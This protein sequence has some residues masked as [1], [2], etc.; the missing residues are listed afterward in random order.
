MTSKKSWPSRSLHF[1]SGNEH[2][3][4][5]TWLALSWSPAENEGEKSSLTVSH[6]CH[7]PLLGFVGA[8]SDIWVQYPYSVSV[9]SIYICAVSVLGVCI[10]Y[11][12]PVL[13]VCVQHLYQV[14][15]YRSLTWR[16]H[17]SN[18]G[19]GPLFRTPT[20]NIYCIGALCPPSLRNSEYNQCNRNYK[21]YL[22]SAI[23][24][25]A[26]KACEPSF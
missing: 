4:G 14:L 20:S 12:A 26:R 10:Q 18:P 1:L 16:H 6:W 21:L 9:F 5:A 19:S 25:Y 3:C 17:R 13:G 8:S 7:Y 15:L 11:A 24:K 2:T 23:P 22:T